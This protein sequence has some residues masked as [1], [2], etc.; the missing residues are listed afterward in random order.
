MIQILPWYSTTSWCIQ[1]TCLD[2][3]LCA[4]MFHWPVEERTATVATEKLLFLKATIDFFLWN[5]I[6]LDITLWIINLDLVCGINGVCLI[7]CTARFLTMNTIT[8]HD[9]DWIAFQG[10]LDIAT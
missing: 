8:C 5:G 3:S 1:D 9:L 6:H 2:Y 10:D 7:R 4:L